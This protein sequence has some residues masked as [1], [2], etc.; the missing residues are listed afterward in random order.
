M[1]TSRRDIEKNAQEMSNGPGRRVIK[2]PGE[3][4]ILFGVGLFRCAISSSKMAS[5][6]SLD[7]EFSVFWVSCVLR[8]PSEIQA[9]PDGDETC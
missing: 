4:D 8:H 1:V 7:R 3:L 2:W 6:Y 5:S 9:L